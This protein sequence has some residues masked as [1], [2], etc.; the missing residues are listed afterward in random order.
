MRTYI[1]LYSLLSI[2]SIFSLNASNKLDQE[3]SI[4][5]IISP[6]SSKLIMPAKIVAYNFPNGFYNPYTGFDINDN[7]YL[8]FYGDSINLSSYPKLVLSEPDD[9]TRITVMLDNLPYVGKSK[10][11]YPSTPYCLSTLILRQYLNFKKIADINGLILVFYP[12]QD[13]PSFIWYSFP[14][15]YVDGFAFNVDYGEHSKFFH[16][17]I[18]EVQ[19]QNPSYPKIIY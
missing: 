14:L 1:I 4:S 5:R 8:S 3:I 6:D 15:L 13:Q 18:K 17:F 11:S 7:F 16:E 2:F 10:Y 19:N 9:I 12:K